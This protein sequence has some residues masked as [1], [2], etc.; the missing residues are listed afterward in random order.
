M[1]TFLALFQTKN[2]TALSWSP[3]FKFSIYKIILHRLQV[4]NVTALSYFL[5]E[6]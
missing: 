5:H 2:K 4:Y 6:N 3:F 1:S